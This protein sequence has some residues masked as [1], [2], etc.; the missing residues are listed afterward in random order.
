MSFRKNN[1]MKQKIK[2]GMVEDHTLFSEAVATSIGV[3][4]SNRQFK[5]EVVFKARNGRDMVEQLKVYG[6]P[7]IIL[8]DIQ[9]P[10]M[11][12]LES[13]LWL[14]A[15][16]PEI[17]VLMLTMHSGEEFIVRAIK[18]GANGYLLK[19]CSAIELLDAIDSIFTKGYFYNDMVTG[20]MIHAFRNLENEA[21]TIKSLASLT[22]REIEVLKYVSTELTYA[23]IAKKMNVSPRTVDGIRDALFEKLN[24]KTRVGLVL[25]AVKNGIVQV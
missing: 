11:D 20:R 1:F 24:V 15:N 14:K 10:E 12:G 23:E 6:D 5:Y 3:A 2:I 17:K 13:L 25:F 22:E 9:M 21:S 7:D 18:N 4:S 19:N 16:R 8:L